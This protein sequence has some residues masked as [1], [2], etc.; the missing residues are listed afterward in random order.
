[1]SDMLLLSRVILYV[2]FLS[3]VFSMALNTAESP[4]SLY[5]SF[6][7]IGLSFLFFQRATFLG[8]P[9]NPIL[10]CVM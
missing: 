9:I 1:M 3:R 10:L 4:P 6:R 2:I 5:N 7:G 8:S